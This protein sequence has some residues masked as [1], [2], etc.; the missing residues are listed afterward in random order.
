MSVSR[1]VAF[2][3]IELLVVIAIIAVLVGLLLPAVQKVRAAAARVKCQNNLKQLGLAAHNFHDANQTFP[4]SISG[5]QGGIA[6][7]YWSAFIALLPYMEQQP[8]YQR[9]YDKAVATNNISLG[10]I[11]DGGLNSLDASTVASYVCPAD[12]L[13]NPPVD[14]FPGTNTYFG[15]TSYRHGYSGLD[16]NDPQY[17]QDG[18]ICQQAV[19]ITAITDG[20][21][22]T[23]MFGEFANFE[24]NW[25]TWSSALLGANIPL[26]VLASGWPSGF[27]SPNAS[28]FYPINPRL[29][30]AVPADPLVMGLQTANRFDA[31]GSRHTGGANFTLADGSVRF[32]SEGVNNNLALFAGMGTRAGGEIISG[33][34]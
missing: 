5:G 27:S 9:F 20:T 31:Y 26:T 2:T 1:R 24:P 30:A 17:G 19:K 21:S 4:M 10:A 12:G 33:N 11:G 8:L 28:T 7:G 23:I 13:P 3:L 15:L 32:I 34:F 14:Q 22:S 29:P 16:A 6:Q 18:V 25:S